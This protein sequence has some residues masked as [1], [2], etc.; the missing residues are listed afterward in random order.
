MKV[1]FVLT[2]T[3]ENVKKIM[4]LKIKDVLRQNCLRLTNQRMLSLKFYLKIGTFPM[5]NV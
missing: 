2:Q 5:K 4:P 3:V 1:Y